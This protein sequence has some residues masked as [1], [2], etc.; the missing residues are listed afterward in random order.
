M[1][2]D[3]SSNYYRS[4]NYTMSRKRQIIN[5]MLEDLHDQHAEMIESAMAYSDMEEA[6]RVIDYVRGL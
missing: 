1:N 6:R 4:V 5:A 2:P 3:Y